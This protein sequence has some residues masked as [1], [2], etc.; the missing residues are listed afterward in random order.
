MAPNL[1]MQNEF[2]SEANDV[3][4]REIDELHG[5]LKTVSRQLECMRRL[6]QIEND[7]RELRGNAV[8]AR[9]AKEGEAGYIPKQS[10]GDDRLFTVPID[11]NDA[12]SSA[13]QDLGY[14][15]E[16]LDDF[17]FLENE[18]ILSALL[19]N[20]ECFRKTVR[21]EAQESILKS[22]NQIVLSIRFLTNHLH[23][24]L[25]QI[26]NRKTEVERIKKIQEE[27]NGQTTREA[28]KK[29]DAGTIPLPD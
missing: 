8:R 12:R 10:L 4:R 11:E 1:P 27:R 28:S 29:R 6:Q 16:R 5:S 3:L 26:A 15:E 9:F 13:I 23:E 2:D 21:E 17:R 18:E 19:Y 20:L 7:L 14:I 24:M 25:D 22:L